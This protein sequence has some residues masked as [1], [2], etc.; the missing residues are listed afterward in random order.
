MAEC[1]VPEGQPPSV[2]VKGDENSEYLMAFD[3]S[4]AES[5]SSDDFAIQ[6]FKL[7]NDTKQ[8]VLVHS[9]ALAGAPMRQH[10]QYMHYLLTNFNI[11]SIVGDYNGGVQFLSAANESALFK[12]SNIKI[13]MIDADWDN[14]ENYQKA[15][16]DAKSQYNKS[17]KRICVLRKPSSAWIRRANELLQ[18]NFDHKRI[19][20]ASKAI[21]D[22]YST[23]IKKK[24]PIDNI[25]FS[26]IIDKEK[27]SSSAKMIDFVEHQE[28]MIELTKVECSLIQITTSPQGTQTF[29][30]PSTLKR[31]TGP[32]KTRKDSYSA[33]VLG[34]WMIKIYYD[35]IEAKNDTVSTF[36]PM[37]IR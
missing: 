21:D 27:Q 17:S 37:F 1:T 33:L 12:K 13:G 5:E 14:I 19:W 10:I 34:N 16:L 20:F 35:M 7:N 24:I 30:L 36:T 8:G 15:L 18:A 4:W 6:I 2:E 32:E 22:Y 11:V 9:Y 28:D 29:D 3:P 26:N 23:Q 25:K 31:Q